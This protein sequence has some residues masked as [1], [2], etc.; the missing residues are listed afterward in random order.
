MV[1][2]SV[3]V[4]SFVFMLLSCAQ[5]LH[6]YT[7]INT[8]RYQSS[9]ALDNDNLY[10]TIQMDHR[11]GFGTHAYL[12]GDVWD[13]VWVADIPHG[14]GLYLSSTTGNKVRSTFIKQ[15]EPLPDGN[16]HTFAP[17]LQSEK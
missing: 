10:L 14:P 1:V 9:L 5:W 11:N 2:V 12:N 13:G 16:C 15:G 8:N 7:R 17:S 6:S 4:R 3:F